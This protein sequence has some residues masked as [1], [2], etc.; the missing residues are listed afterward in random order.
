MITIRIASKTRGG[1]AEVDRRITDHGL[2]GFA[3]LRRG[4][5]VT[6][7]LLLV[8]GHWLLVPPSPAQTPA[9]INYQG[10]LLDGT[11]LF[12][13]T[14]GLTLQLFSAPASGSLLYADSNTVT[15]VDGLYA[16]YLGDGT[17]TGNLEA[18]WTNAQV[19]LEAVVNGTVLTPRERMVSVPYAR[20]VQGLRM[21]HT[22][23]VVLNAEA[24]AN[25]IQAGTSYATIGGGL[26]HSIG[27]ISDYATIS[28]G[29]ANR[30]S[31]NATG[32]T[33]SGGSFNRVSSNALYAT[34]AGGT[35]NDI[36]AFSSH[37]AIGGGNQNTIDQNADHSTI[38]GGR[39]NIML[40]GANYS[41]IGGGWFNSFSNFAAYSA[42]VGGYQN[43]ALPGAQYGAIGGGQGNQLGSGSSYATVPGGRN[44]FATTY[45]MAA[46]RRARALHPGS[47][48]WGDNTDA[49]ISSTADNQFLIRASGGLGV[50]VTN[51]GSGLTAD[52][53]GRLRLRGST[54]GAWLYDTSLA[55]DRGFVGMSDGDHVGFYGHAGAGWGFLMNVTNGHIG[56]GKFYPVHTI[57]VANGAYLSVGGTWT[58]VSD[59]N[60]KRDFAPVDPESILLKVAA[61]PIT[62]WSYTTEPGVRHIGPTAQDFHAAFGVGASP[63]AL[64]QIDPDG[65]ALAAIQALAK[66]NAEL[67]A[68][69]SG[70]SDQ[71]SGLQ[72]ENARLREEMAA[73]KQ[74]L[75]L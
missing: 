3:L 40:P 8:T 39:N 30:I 64:A 23:N 49:D 15:V 72:E 28:G 46:G 10:R 38:G 18:A 37:S 60:R 43:A 11:N 52:F 41:V 71:V 1:R 27:E 29:L 20:T 16:T 55:A 19:W 13:G 67:A 2:P 32:A 74:R 61:L 35:V 48:V 36:G 66:E 14:I 7:L 33:I 51:M 12:N 34:I 75:G 50:N 58:S 59:V 4:K 26:N 62:T 24:G 54:A 6:L 68:K 25:S 70:F 9:L 63:T 21:A 56:I 42:I 17:I 73:I 53:G 65:V 45:A 31:T 69:V 47:F 22:N 44:N 5:L 57:D